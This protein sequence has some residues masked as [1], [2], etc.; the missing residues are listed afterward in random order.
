MLSVQIAEAAPLIGKK[1]TDEER[2][3][4]EIVRRSLG[5]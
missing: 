1:V 2:T 3:A 4:V 5:A